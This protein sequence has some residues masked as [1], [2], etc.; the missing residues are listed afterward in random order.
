MNLSKIFINIA[1]IILLALVTL[2]VVW[3]VF[4]VIQTELDIKY[5]VFFHDLEVLVGVKRYLL[6]QV[7]LLLFVLVYIM[8]SLFD[9]NRHGSANQLL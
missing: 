6:C 1:K 2:D 7:L 3:T 4:M 5:N 9:R 8:L